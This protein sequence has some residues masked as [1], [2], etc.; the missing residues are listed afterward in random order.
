MSKPEDSNTQTIGEADSREPYEA[1]RFECEELFE[2]LALACGKTTG[3]PAFG[4]Q[5]LVRAS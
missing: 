2:V 5:H 1:P 3:N 4:C